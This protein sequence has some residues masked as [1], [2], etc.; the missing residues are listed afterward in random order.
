MFSEISKRDDRSCSSLGS[1]ARQ[2]QLET[3]LDISDV[4]NMIIFQEFSNM[5]VAE[6]R[7]FRSYA[8]INGHRRTGQYIEVV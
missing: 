7:P 2:G 4:D 5:E 1:V 8:A 6:K 3:K